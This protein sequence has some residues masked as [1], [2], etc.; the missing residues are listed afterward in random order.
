M[1]QQYFGKSHTF[2]GQKEK[3]YS[4]KKREGW[5]KIKEENQG[6]KA[7]NKSQGNRIFE[8][9]GNLRAVNSVLE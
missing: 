3:K 4:L 7:L 5:L 2:M 8:K 9:I 1:N 6:N